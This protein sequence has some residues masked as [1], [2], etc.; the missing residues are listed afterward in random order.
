MLEYAHMT[1]CLYIFK[2]SP[3]RVGMVK[4]QWDNV[5]ACSSVPSFAREQVHNNCSS[6]AFQA[7]K[8]MR[9]SLMNPAPI[10]P[11]SWKVCHEQFSNLVSK[12]ET[13]RLPLV[14]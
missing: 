6:M 5:L 3:T 12:P 8:L 2:F 1:A 14:S 7:R 4:G 13:R 11:D 10:P 9:H